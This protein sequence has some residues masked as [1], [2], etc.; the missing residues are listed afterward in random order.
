M[1]KRT[2]SV[3][4]VL[5]ISLAQPKC[6]IRVLVEIPINLVNFSLIDVIAINI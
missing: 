4:E 2:Y 5:H 1:E 3:E 6:D